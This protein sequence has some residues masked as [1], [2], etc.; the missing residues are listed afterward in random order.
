MEAKN[1]RIFEILHET[2]NY[3]KEIVSKVVDMK[4]S[5]GDMNLQLAEENSEWL[6]SKTGV[7]EYDIEKSTMV[8]QNYQKYYYNLT[9]TNIEEIREQPSLLEGGTLKNY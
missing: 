5:D 2:D 6:K 4:K 1:N 8:T 3:L 9:H 7:T